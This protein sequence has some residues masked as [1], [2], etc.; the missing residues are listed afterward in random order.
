[1]LESY[2]HIPPDEIDAHVIAVVSP[3]APTPLLPA[4]S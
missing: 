3:I 4:P 1:L 2:S